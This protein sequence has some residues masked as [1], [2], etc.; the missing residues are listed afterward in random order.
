MSDEMRE[1]HARAQRRPFVK[2]PIVGHFATYVRGFPMAVTLLLEREHPSAQRDSEFFE[3][4][5]LAPAA[6]LRTTFRE[7][8]TDRVRS[9]GADAETD[10]MDPRFKM[11]PGER[12]LKLTH[13]D[14]PIVW[15]AVTEYGDDFWNFVTPGR[16]TVTVT[17]NSATAEPFEIEVRAPTP[18]EEL[19]L[20]TARSATRDGMTGHWPPWYDVDFT[21]IQGPIS[22]TDPLRSAPLLPGRR[23][24]R[25]R[26]RRRARR[27]PDRS[28]RRP[29]RTVRRAPPRRDL[30][31]AQADRRSERRDRRRHHEMGRSRLACSPDPRGPRRHHAEVIPTGWSLL[32]AT[33]GARHVPGRRVDAVSVGSPSARRHVT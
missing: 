12:Q 4:P 1:E 7:V 9:W 33:C 16:Y 26:P 22:K 23:D 15:G 14:D 6:D 25:E 2:P 20:A 32:T 5:P 24:A 10:D 18:L 21:K 13:L 11:P 19:E 3:L 28:P 30:R 31:E 8:G 17:Y 29:L 27:D